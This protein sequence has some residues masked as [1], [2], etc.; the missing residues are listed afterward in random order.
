MEENRKGLPAVY[1]KLDMLVTNLNSVFPSVHVIAKKNEVGRSEDWAHAPQN[2]LET[3][4]VVKVAMEISWQGK[5]SKHWVHPLAFVAYRNRRQTN[6]MVSTG[7][8]KKTTAQ[9]AEELYRLLCY[10][11]PLYWLT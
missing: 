7:Q 1:R 5:Q 4:Q 10:V 11:N 6:E 9:G 2:F 8:L 3:N